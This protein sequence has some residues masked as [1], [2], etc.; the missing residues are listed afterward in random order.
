MM[1]VFSSFLRNLLFA[2]FFFFFHVALDFVHVDMVKIC[3]KPDTWF[4]VDNNGLK[5]S[6]AMVGGAYIRHHSD[7]RK[8]RSEGDK[9]VIHQT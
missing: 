3:I 9:P 1:R 5:G 7:I 6:N 8:N 2:F 4:D